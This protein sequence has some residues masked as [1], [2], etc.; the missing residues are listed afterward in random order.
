MGSRKRFLVL[1]VP[2]ALAVAGL[3][4]ATIPAAG[5]VIHGC[6]QKNVGNLRVIDPA[7]DKCR[8][9]EIAIS[10]NAQGPKGDPGPQGPV[11]PQGPQGPAGPPGETLH[12]TAGVGLDL[13][14]TPA[15]FETHLFSIA[16]THR[17]P[18]GCSPGQVPRKAGG[19]GW[20]C[21]SGGNGGGTVVRAYT[22]RG[23]ADVPVHGNFEIAALDLP[24]GSYVIF[25][26]AD[27][28]TSDL[29]E[30]PALCQLS[31][32]D[33][34]KTWLHEGGEPVTQ[35]ITL[36]DAVTFDEPTRVTLGCGTYQGYA[37]GRIL[38][39]SVGGVN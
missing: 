39:I 29:D 27:L 9:S 10:W 6:Y 28:I 1:A 11:G 23:G 35:P 32:G 26:R 13:L 30:Q 12:Y 7:T 5:G 3:A 14:E 24:A 31:T 8:P 25:A 34:S 2:S 33:Q 17:L 4:Y 22:A 37:S 16:A 18:Q 19:T 38:A 20:T 36:Q 21:G 15:P